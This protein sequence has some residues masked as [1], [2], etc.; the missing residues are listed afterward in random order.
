MFFFHPPSNARPL[1]L[2]LSPYDRPSTCVA[3]GSAH[4]V[5]EP[6]VSKCSAS[7]YLTRRLRPCTSSSRWPVEEGNEVEATSVRQSVCLE[8]FLRERKRLNTHCFRGLDVIVGWGVGKKKAICPCMR[9]CRILKP[10]ST[11]QARLLRGTS[12]NR[13]DVTVKA[14]CGL[15]R[16]ETVQSGRHDWRCR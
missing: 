9:W 7:R 6:R 12:S 11:R 1:F 14:A 15:S 13:L 16:S 2:L 5:V 8:C 3:S 4:G 10:L